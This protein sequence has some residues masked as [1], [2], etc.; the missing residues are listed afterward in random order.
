MHSRLIEWSR[1]VY[2]AGIV[3][4]LVFVIPIDWFP[5]QLAK[6]AV[7]A[8]FLLVALVLFAAGGGSK[9]FLRTHGLKLALLTA[10]LPLVY[11]VSAYFSVDRTLAFLGTGADTDTVLFTVLASLAF[12]ASAVLF[13]TLRDGIAS[14][15]SGVCRACG[16]GS[17]P[18]DSHP[19]RHRGSPVPDVQRPFGQPHRQVE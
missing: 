18:M 11:L 16:S 10:L 12:I 19:V 17:F 1:Y 6:V 15:Q 5:F 4:A 9:E 3:L 8:V 2:L 13:R 7:F 14:S